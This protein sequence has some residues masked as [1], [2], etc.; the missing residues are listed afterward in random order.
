MNFLLVKGCA[1]G[2]RPF[3][4]PL[5]RSL[6]PCPIHLVPSPRHALLLMAAALG[7][8]QPGR[9]GRRPLALIEVPGAVCRS[10]DVPGRDGGAG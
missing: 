9:I 5:L 8:A 2:P 10:A 1:R 6:Q 4:T 3:V 7:F